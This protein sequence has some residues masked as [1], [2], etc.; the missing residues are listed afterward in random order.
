MATIKNTEKL[1]E[2]VVT[3]E[4][5]TI[6]AWYTPQIPVSHGPAEYGGLPG[7]ILELITAM[8]CAQPGNYIKL[9]NK[10]VKMLA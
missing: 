9:I 4:V 7:L 3:A 1:E 5:E 8:V 2:V 6:T 10:I